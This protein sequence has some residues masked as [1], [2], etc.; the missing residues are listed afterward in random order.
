MQRIKIIAFFAAM[1]SVALLFTAFGQKASLKA[2]KSPSKESKDKAADKTSPFVRV[3]TSETDAAEP[4]ITSAPD[5]GVYLIWVEHRAN[6][7]SDVFLQKFNAEKKPLSEKVRVNPKAGQATAWRGD[8]PTVKVGSDNTVYVGW[9]G[10]VEV[11]EGSAND[12][13]LSVSRDG[14]RKFDAPVKVNDDKIPAVHGMHSMAIDKNN[15]IYFSWLDERYLKN[16]THARHQAKTEQKPENKTEATEKKHQHSEANREI[17]FAVSKDGG[18][19]FGKNKRIAADGCPCCKTSILTAPDGRVYISWRQVLPDDFRHIAITSS[20]DGGKSFEPMTIVSDDK[21]QI[22][23][24][25]VSGAALAV[26]ADNILRTVWYTAGDAGKPGLYR[27]ES[28][29]GGKT[30]SPRAHLYEGRVAGTPLL[31]SGKTGELK[32][33]WQS[34]GKILQLTTQMLPNGAGNIEEIGTGRFPSATIAGEKLFVGFIQN[35][36]D[37]RSIWLY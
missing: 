35:E 7:E 2:I 20:S 24:C 16:E 17:Y 19:S 28:K 12:L 29:D 36:R 5:G 1:L 25:P 26:G 3:S 37:K 13:Y 21:W 18:K 27:A 6:K 31:L 10:R 4:D 14:G 33:V 11:K 23:G 34:D 32:I 15:H 22:G 9:S 8:P 30:F